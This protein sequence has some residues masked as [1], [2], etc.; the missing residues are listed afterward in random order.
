M[1]WGEELGSIHVLNASV[2]SRLP[3]PERG[4][5]LYLS[6]AQAT[7]RGGMCVTDYGLRGLAGLKFLHTLDLSLTQVTTKGG[8]RSSVVAEFHADCQDVLS[9]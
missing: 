6:V 1:T 4:F 7:D 8:P 9:R 3:Q 2:L 5:G